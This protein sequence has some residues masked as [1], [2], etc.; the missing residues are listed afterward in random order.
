MQ[1]M[2]ARALQTAL[3]QVLRGERVSG[4][5]LRRRSNEGA[6]FP[7]RLSG[8]PVTSAAGV[9]R[10]AILVVGAR[11]QEADQPREERAAGRPPGRSG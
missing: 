7:L 8:R 6:P 2:V 10:G 1:G 5:D 9:L 3:S 4:L 11:G